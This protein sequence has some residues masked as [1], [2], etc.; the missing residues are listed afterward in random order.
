MVGLLDAKKAYDPNKFRIGGTKPSVAVAAKKIKKTNLNAEQI[1]KELRSNNKIDDLDEDYWNRVCGIGEQQRSIQN[2]SDDEPAT[3]APVQHNYV[4]KNVRE[5]GMP[6]GALSNPGIHP[7]S[8]AISEGLPY[9]ASENGQFFAGRSYAARANA[10]PNLNG[11]DWTDDM[12][13]RGT[14][15]VAR[16]AG[17][18]IDPMKRPNSFEISEEAFKPMV[19]TRVRTG[20]IV[21]TMDGNAYETY[22]EEMFAPDFKRDQS[23]SKEDLRK[24]NPRLIMMNGGF[25]ENRPPPRKKEIAFKGVQGP[26]AGRNPWGEQ[27]YTDRVREMTE[28]QVS[29]DLF[30]NRN[31]FAPVEAVDDRQSMGFVGYVPAWRYTPAI[32]PTQRGRSD[33]GRAWHAGPEPGT[34]APNFD[35]TRVMGPG[36]ISKKKHDLLGSKPARAFAVGG[37]GVQ[38]TDSVRNPDPDRERSFVTQRAVDERKT[39]ASVVEREVYGTDVQRDADYHHKV[40]ANHGEAINCER[41]RNVRY[42]N[43]SVEG[44]N[45]LHVEDQGN[46]VDPYRSGTKG[47]LAKAALRRPNIDRHVSNEEGGYRDA[48]YDQKDPVNKS[49]KGSR[50]RTV[51][52]MQRDGSYVRPDPRQDPVKRRNEAYAAS[53]N[54]GRWGRIQ[55]TQDAS[56]AHYRDSRV[57]RRDKQRLSY[58]QKGKSFVDGFDCDSDGPARSARRDRRDPQRESYSAKAGARSRTFEREDSGYY[59]TND[60]PEGRQCTRKDL[61]SKAYRQTQRYV[62]EGEDHGP[63]TWDA[64]Y[65]ESQTDNRGVRDDPYNPT[66]KWT[67]NAFQSNDR[68]IFKNQFNQGSRA[69]KKE[70][71]YR[72]DPEQGADFSDFE[73]TARRPRPYNRVSSK[74][75]DDTIDNFSGYD[76][77]G[78]EQWDE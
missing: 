5:R 53:G 69:C 7:A 12:Y 66:S 78:I 2:D 42:R 4:L 72:F 3:R 76:A 35:P 64:R 30:H 52:S 6:L 46:T 8:L 54:V 32:T 47:S 14:K 56:D 73:V 26:D 36:Q 11:H 17:R 31:G 1:C 57:D 19:E 18:P 49:Y 25:D 65:H 59:P 13:G 28:H 61:T 58:E 63:G 22:E 77:Y 39:R 67:P 15:I 48:R 23:I 33:Q 75:P 62:P 60:D 40:R 41:G 70:V 20:I 45:Y 68:V 21:N 43:A 29:R 55:T 44:A 16:E 51:D 38:A 74:R 9:V 50:Y 34:A 71:T 37:Q 10:N 24:T 27:I